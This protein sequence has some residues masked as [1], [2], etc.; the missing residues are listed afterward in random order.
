MC[1]S[2]KSTELVTYDLSAQRGN[3][4]DSHGPLNFSF[5]TGV[6]RGRTLLKHSYFDDETLVSGPTAREVCKIVCF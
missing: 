6:W 4:G 5:C 1:Y 3:H 2:V